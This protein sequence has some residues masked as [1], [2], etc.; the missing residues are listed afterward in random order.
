MKL[1][2][3][4]LIINFTIVVLI[5]GSAAFAFY[6]VMYNVL[7]SQQS[8]QLQN[9]LNEFLYTYRDMQQNS[10]ED[11]YK[12]IDNDKLVNLSPK[13]LTKNLDFILETQPDG[14]KVSLFTG[15]KNIV[16]PKGNFDLTTFL[17]ENPFVSINSYTNE[18]GV[19]FY[20]GRSL[21][22]DLLTDLS[23]KINA[24]VALIWDGTPVEISNPENNNKF[25]VSLKNAYSELTGAKSSSTYTSDKEASDLVAAVFNPGTSNNSKISFL[26]FNTINEAADLRANIRYVIII[27]GVAGSILALDPHPCIY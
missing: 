5:L 6:S 7:S 20:Y 11:F 27:I 13:S 17:K 21:S 3:R 19:I 16:F 8:K 23:G 4:I 14:E 24:D 2:L 15:K 12:F 10:D 26:V 1:S 22:A 18:K 9:S 25:I